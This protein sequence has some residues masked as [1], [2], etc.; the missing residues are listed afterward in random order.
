[1]W[2]EYDESCMPEGWAIG[3]AARWG[4]V[5]EEQLDAVLA[6]AETLCGKPDTTR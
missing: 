4:S 6:F 1:M 5:T 2:I 3:G